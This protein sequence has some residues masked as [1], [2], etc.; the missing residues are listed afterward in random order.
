MSC[1]SRPGTRQ[2][3]TG[4][5]YAG[6]G[7]EPVT[8]EFGRVVHQGPQRPAGR[9]HRSP[10]AAATETAGNGHRNL[11][12]IFCFPQVSTEG[13]DVDSYFFHSLASVLCRGQPF[14]SQPH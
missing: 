9:L 2:Q 1:P 12:H 8:A 11:I 3:A 7:A 6:G 5:V 4:H 10:T 14:A 13:W